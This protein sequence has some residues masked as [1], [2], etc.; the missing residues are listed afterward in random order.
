MRKVEGEEAGVF[1]PFGRDGGGGY[2]FHLGGVLRRSLRAKVRLRS[3]SKCNTHP[4]QSKQTTGQT[5]PI[6]PFLAESQDF[7]HGLPS[8]SGGRQFPQTWYRHTPPGRICRFIPESA[9]VFPLNCFW[10]VSWVAC[11]L[12]HHL[13]LV[14]DAKATTARF[15]PAC[16]VRTTATNGCDS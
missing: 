5:A 2:V 6:I 7:D 4:A 11:R 1:K 14:L 3:D 9:D 15:R 10:N 12:S 13:L 16:R 8:P